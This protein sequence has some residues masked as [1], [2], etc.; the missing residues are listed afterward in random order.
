[1]KLSEHF[2][3]DEMT[4]SQEAAR[5]NV[6]NIPAEQH[7]AA[8]KE[9]C[10]HVLEPLRKAAGR[11]V[12]IS[13]GYRSPTVNVLVG[14]GN[15]SD[16]CLGRAADIIIPG[17][18]SIDTCK[19]I[20]KLNLPFKQLINEFSSWTHVSIPLPGIAPKWEVLTAMRNGG[21]VVYL[22]GL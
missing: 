1:M 14:G 6:P 13:S 12:V 22:K 19:L 20:L 18:S 16:H 2:T 10:A 5:R 17:Q 8:M 15:T 3:L 11:P 7:I 4:V 9:L 21:A